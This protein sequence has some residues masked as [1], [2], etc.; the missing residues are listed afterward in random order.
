MSK[1]SKPFNNCRRK[2][3]VFEEGTS[4]VKKGMLSTSLAAYVWV[5]SGISLKKIL[6]NFVFVK[7]AKGCRFILVPMIFCYHE[8]LKGSKILQIV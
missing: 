4:N 8:T 3:R 6:R 5:F 7:F 2:K 1:L